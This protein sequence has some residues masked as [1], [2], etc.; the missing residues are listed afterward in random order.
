VTARGTQEAV[1]ARI[2]AGADDFVAKP[3]ALAEL[4]ARMMAVVP[5][6]LDVRAPE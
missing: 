1:V 6:S 5:M 4:R 2:R 3:F